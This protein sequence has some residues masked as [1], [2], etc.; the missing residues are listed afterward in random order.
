MA[1]IKELKA[2]TAKDETIAK[3]AADKGS[4]V[5]RWTIAIRVDQNGNVVSTSEELKADFL[6][7]CLG[8][9]GNVGV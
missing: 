3:A 6:S 7:T 8:E 4:H 9:V 5:K 1:K 2:P